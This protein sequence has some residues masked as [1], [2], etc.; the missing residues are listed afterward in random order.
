MQVLEVLIL[1]ALS[2][3]LALMQALAALGRLLVLVQADQLALMLLQVLVLMRRDCQ[4]RL[5][6]CRNQMAFVSQ[7]PG[8]Q[9]RDQA[10]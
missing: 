4:Q 6:A 9:R 8:G 5:W 10:W 2:L 3:G 1:R 7:Q